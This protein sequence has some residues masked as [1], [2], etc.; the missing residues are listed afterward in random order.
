[1]QKHNNNKKIIIK[2]YD[3]HCNTAIFIALKFKIY[4]KKVHIKTMSVLIKILNFH[5]N[6]KYDIFKYYII[7]KYFI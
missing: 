7:F 1:M 4:K 2:L 5:I 3:S 6:I